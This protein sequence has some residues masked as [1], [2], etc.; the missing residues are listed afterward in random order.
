MPLF[1][2]AG[3]DITGA[4]GAASSLGVGDSCFITS[5]FPFVPVPRP[6]HPVKT[7]ARTIV[8]IPNPILIMGS[9]LLVCG[10]QTRGRYSKNGSE[11]TG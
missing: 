8:A 9:L 5:G 3:E 6:P 4:L 7:A 11:E 2:L 10:E 1:V